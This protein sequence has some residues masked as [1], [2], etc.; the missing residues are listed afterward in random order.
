LKITKN[1]VYEDNSSSSA[2]TENQIDNLRAYVKS[3]ADKKTNQL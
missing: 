2:L 3:L 1:T